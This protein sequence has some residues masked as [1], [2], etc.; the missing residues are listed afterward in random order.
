M[1]LRKTDGEISTSFT[2]LLFQPFDDFKLMKLKS[3]I[4]E[5]EM[6]NSLN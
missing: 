1:N 5:V 2:N 4:R 3:Y 6:E